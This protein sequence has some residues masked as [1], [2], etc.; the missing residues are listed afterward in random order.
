M[1]NLALKAVVITVFTIAATLLVFAII[2]TQ[3]LI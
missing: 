1:K 2:N 3:K